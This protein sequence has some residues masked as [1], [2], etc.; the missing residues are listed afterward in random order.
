[1]GQLAVGSMPSQVRIRSRFPSI[2]VRIFFRESS[3]EEE[4]TVGSLKS[5]I[6]TRIPALRWRDQL[7]AK[8]ARRIK[9]LR[10]KNSALTAK[11]R[12]LRAQ[13]EAA[14]GSAA[15]GTGGASPTAGGG[16]G[17]WRVTP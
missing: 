1:M 12:A 9:E 10:E 3:V 16:L 5:R 17:S 2:E 8:H 6:K 13:L 7:L 14:K 11:N 4:S 15:P